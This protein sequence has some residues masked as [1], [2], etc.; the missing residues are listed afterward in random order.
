[1]PAL[2]SWDGFLGLSIATYSLS[3]GEGQTKEFNPSQKD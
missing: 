3:P 1:M 2:F